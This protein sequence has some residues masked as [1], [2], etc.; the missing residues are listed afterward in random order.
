MSGFHKPHLQ[1]SM[2]IIKV[3]F[4]L[5]STQSMIDAP[6]TL[7]FNIMWY[8]VLA[9]SIYHRVVHQYWISD[10][11]HSNQGAHSWQVCS[12]LFLVGTHE[13]H[14]R[15]VTEIDHP[16]SQSVGVLFYI[17]PDIQMINRHWALI[18][19]SHCMHNLIKTSHCFLNLSWYNFP[20][21][22]N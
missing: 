1:L 6:N 10:C 14:W 11:R 8:T 16:L 5:C 20:A 2:V 7:I 18:K 19:S 3:P 15:L 13:T 21:F 17:E 9:E 12:V 22:Y 4:A